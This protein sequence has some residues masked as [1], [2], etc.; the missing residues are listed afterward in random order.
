MIRYAWQRRRYGWL[1]AAL[2]GPALG[3]IA[4]L[5]DGLTRPGAISL[6]VFAMAIVLWVS[7]AIPLAVTGLL[8][9]AA[10]PLFGAMS[11]AE[12]FPLFGN[13]AV[14]FILGALVLAA[15]LMTTGLSRRVSLFLLL[16]LRRLGAAAVDGDIAHVRAACR[17]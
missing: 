14:F 13:P 10:L 5:P 15:A 3:A 12:A 4:P 6:G 7:G 2:S 9:L 16:A 17:A 11:P 1:V 8:I